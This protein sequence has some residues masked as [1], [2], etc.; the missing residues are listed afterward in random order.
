[1]TDHTRTRTPVFLFILL[2]SLGALTSIWRV[3]DWGNQLSTV[4]VYSEANALRA[5][6]NFLDQG[7]TRYDG[8]WNALYPGMYPDDGFARDPAEAAYYLSPEGVYTHYPPGPEY[9]LY[10]ATKLFGPEPVSRL[11][12][13]PIAI[14]WVSMLCFGLAIRRRFGAGV[15][16]LVMAACALTPAV[17]D[18]FV[19]LHY[20]GY[21][22]ALLLVE[23]A[24]AIGM[25][26]RMAPFALL[27]FLQ[28]WLSFDYVFLVTL[29]PLA[30]ELVLPKIDPGYQPRWKLAVSRTVLA[31][32]GF[33]AAHALH[34]AQVWAYWGSL[35]AAARDFAGA[36]A[37]RAGANE[38]GGPLDYLLLTLSNWKLYFYG[39]HPLNL[40]LNLPD[41]ATPENWSMFRVLGL[42]LGPWWLV[43]TLGLMLWDQV[44]P[45]SA[46]RS[47]RMD[48]HFVCG[49]GMLISSLWIMA[50]PD[51]AGHHLHFLYRH[52]FFA[53]FVAVLF[54]ATA[55]RRVC[56]AARMPSPVHSGIV[57]TRP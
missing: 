15:G 27:G 52:L 38:I 1:M 17:T 39:L 14:G 34:F 23:I 18:G 4:D 29:V 25:N 8:L 42:S 19:G 50:M 36:A 28:G 20:Q 32:A 40:T 21:A 43:V 12:L 31:G 16:W 37:H 56:A 13:L 49:T 54:G 35:D 46:N 2:C 10:A 22:A 24:G 26:A 9:L 48:W 47:F 30:L 57:S 55:L 53:F 6:H 5:V 7:L 45:D 33:A 3:S 41:P 51:H 44:H 11:R